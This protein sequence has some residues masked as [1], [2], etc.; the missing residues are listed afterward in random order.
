MIYR[1]RSR[2]IR[3]M[4]LSSVAVFLLLF[5]ILYA[6]TSVQT[7]SSLDIFADLISQNGGSF[8]KPGNEGGNFDALPFGPEKMNPESPFTTRFFS[9]RFDQ[10]NKSAFVDTA[11]ISSITKDEAVD[12][13]VK[14]LENGRE[15]GWIGDYRYKVY[16][17][18]FGQA[19]I[20]ISGTDTRRM[21]Q[22][23][24]LNTATIFAG[25]IIVVLIL[26]MR[27][28]KRA[29]KP[30]AASYEKQK[31]FIT[32]AS[33]ELKT[34]LTII[35]ADL[36][37]A[38]DELGKNEWLNDIRDVSDGMTAMVGKLVTL[39]RLDE[40]QTK[41]AMLPFA[42]SDA[43]GDTAEAFRSVMHSRDVAFC[44]DIAP[45]VTYTGDEASLRQLLSIL[46]DNAVKY[47]DAGGSVAVT[48]RGGKHPVLTVDNT[49]KD[50]DGMDLKRLF[51]RF[52]RADE[53]RAAIPGSGVGLSIAQAIVEKHHGQIE[54][55][56]PD[57]ATI[58][59]WVRL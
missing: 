44:V 26:V 11:S 24:M 28:S 32:D 52:Y 15:R 16:E 56:K 4:M 13:A 19:V 10:N 50:V 42:L 46:L 27:L 1:L 31:Q 43:L 33:H 35:R 12:Y 18:D 17:T 55:Q 14:A 29:V 37:L 45:G 49:F 40:D 21:N 30:I 38:E 39:A 3:I 36:E 53:A 8:P 2:F 22:M 54:A 7:N 48:F 57:H 59:F 58:R 25:G 51:D 47:C 6:I 34:P 41:L 5:L 23:F 20:F 9:V